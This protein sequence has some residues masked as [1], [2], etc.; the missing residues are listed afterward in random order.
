MLVTGAFIILAILII[1]IGQLPLVP[2]VARF[3]G[4]GE[5]EV[6]AAEEEAVLSSYGWVDQ[7]NGVVRIPIREAID[8][9]IEQGLPSRQVETPDEDEEGQA[10]DAEAPA[11]EGDAEAPAE[12]GDAEAPAEEGDAEAPAEETPEGQ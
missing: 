6:V 9:Q 4:Q 12:E 3:G 1:L 10:G 7:E 11:E 2:E 8:L 5:W